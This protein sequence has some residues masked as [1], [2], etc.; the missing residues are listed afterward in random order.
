LAFDTLPSI[1]VSTSIV[2]D[3]SSATMVVSSAAA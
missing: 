1:P 3:Q 2:P